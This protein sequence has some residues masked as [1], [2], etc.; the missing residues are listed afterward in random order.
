MTLVDVLMYAFNSDLCSV[1]EHR[2]EAL[3]LEQNEIR[4]G[5]VC[6]THRLKNTVIPA[7]RINKPLRYITF[8]FVCSGRPEQ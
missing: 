4:Q 6:G 8:V 1:V 2:F 5:A 7:L 3:S